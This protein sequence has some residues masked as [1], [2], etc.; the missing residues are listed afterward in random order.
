MPKIGAV[1]SRFPEQELAIHRLCNQ[2]PDF[3]GNCEDYDEAASALRHWKDAGPEFDARVIE[4][5]DILAE[6]ETDICKDLSSHLLRLS[7][8]G[9]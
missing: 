4:Y 7:Q 3:L 1:I 8:H 2:D 9:D 6:I 5:R